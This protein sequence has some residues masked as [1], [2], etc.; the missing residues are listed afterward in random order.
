MHVSLS[1]GPRDAKAPAIQFGG[2]LRELWWKLCHDLQL[3][4]RLLLP[5]DTASHAS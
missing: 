1:V 5:K 4:S 2:H 3:C